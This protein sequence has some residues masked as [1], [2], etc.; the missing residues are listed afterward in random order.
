MIFRKKIKYYIVTI[1]TK[2]EITKVEVKARSK[3]NA[4][5]IVETILLHCDLWHC[6]SKNDFKLLCKKIDK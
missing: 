1:I 2:N 3:R 4:I 5:N 6:E